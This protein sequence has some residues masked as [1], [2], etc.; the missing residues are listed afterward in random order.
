MIIL[1]YGRSAPAFRGDDTSP[2]MRL[3]DRVRQTF[4]ARFIYGAFRLPMQ[5]GLMQS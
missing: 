5:K 4:P 2:R 1:G 3:H